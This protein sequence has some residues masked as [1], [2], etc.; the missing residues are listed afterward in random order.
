MDLIDILG[1]YYCADFA[2]AEVNGHSVSN[3]VVSESAG[4]LSIR[5]KNFLNLSGK[6]NITFTWPHSKSTTTGFTTSASI[7]PSEAT[8]YATASTKGMLRIFRS[9][10]LFRFPRNFCVHISALKVDRKDLRNLQDSLRI[11]CSSILIAS[12]ILTVALTVSVSKILCRN[13][14]FLK[15]FKDAGILFSL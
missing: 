15:S 8:S 5:K 10:H 1:Y 14:A 11:W 3:L 4:Q 2:S 7:M 12:W 9:F 13:A 6:G